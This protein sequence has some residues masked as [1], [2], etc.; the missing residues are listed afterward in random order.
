VK[1]SPLSRRGFTLVELMAAMTVLSLL[2]VALVAMLDQAMRGWQSAQRGMDARREVRTALQLLESDLKGM[3][4]TSGRPAFI[5]LDANNSSQLTF[6]TLLNANAQGTNTPGDLCAVQYYVS[7]NVQGSYRLIRRLGTS[8][9]VLSNLVS[10]SAITSADS[11]LGASPVTEELAGNVVYF[12]AELKRWVG[13]NLAG[14]DSLGNSTMWQ[15]KP[16]LVQLELT[17]YPQQKAQAF[18]NASDWTDTNNIQKFGKTYLWR[19]FP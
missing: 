18:K 7:N 1:S 9:A 13:D 10:Q 8:P 2:M 19:I 16:D 3:V 5:S 4:V 11:L 17:A 15:N 14:D 6:L 12:R